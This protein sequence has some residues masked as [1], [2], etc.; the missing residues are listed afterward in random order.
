ME[1]LKCEDIVE[2]EDGK[3]YVVTGYHSDD[4]KVWVEPLGDCGETKHD[5]SEIVNHWSK[6]NAESEGL[7]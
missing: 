5:W 7:T 6:S 3:M 2:L 4:Q 1:S